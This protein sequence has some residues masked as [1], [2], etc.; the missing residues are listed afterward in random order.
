M[1]EIV[2]LLTSGWFWLGVIVGLFIMELIK[3]RR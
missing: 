2:E 3:R 1:N